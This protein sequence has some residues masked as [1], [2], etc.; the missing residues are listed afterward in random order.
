LAAQYREFGHDVRVLGFDDMKTRS[1]GVW[2][3]VKFPL[4]VARQVTP[5]LR[6]HQL[7]VLDCST[8]DAWALRRRVLHDSGAILVTRSHGLEHR[9]H[10]ARKEFV[11]ASGVPLSWKYPIYHGGIHL[12]QIERSIRMSDRTFV[13]NERDRQYVIESFAVPP[14]AAPVVRNGLPP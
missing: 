9:G 2:D 6:R 10:D 11:R 1:G 7:D 8:G 3:Q 12:R 5:L 13:L 4:F 14:D